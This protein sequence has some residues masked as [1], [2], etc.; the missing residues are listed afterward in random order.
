MLEFNKN[1]N[2]KKIFK[3]V[4]TFFASIFLLA[5]NFISINLFN[6]FNKNSSALI[7]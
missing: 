5:I 3:T 2:N 1:K 6:N 7:A 4:T